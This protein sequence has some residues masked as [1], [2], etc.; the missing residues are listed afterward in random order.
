MS[1]GGYNWLANVGIEGV[2]NKTQSYIIF[3]GDDT[4]WNDQIYYDQS[5]ERFLDLMEHQGFA[6]QAVRTAFDQID[7]KNVDIKGLGF[8]RR[9]FPQSMVET[10][11]SFCRRNSVAILPSI[12]EQAQKIGEDVFTYHRELAEGA[13]DVLS[14][15][16]NSGKYRL[17]LFTAGDKEIQQW[18]LRDVN[19]GGNFEAVEIPSRKTI[20]SLRKLL[21][22]HCIDPKR[23]WMVGNSWAS[24]I[25]PALKLGLRAIWVQSKSWSYDFSVPSVN[26]VAI[27][28]LKEI[29]GVL[30]VY[31]DKRIR[32][33]KIP[34]QPLALNVTWGILPTSRTKRQPKSTQSASTE[35]HQLALPNLKE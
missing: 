34:Q 16:K 29:P 11:W 13:L 12:T 21:I 33:P 14:E 8:S 9:R 7:R 15:L 18:K 6:Q 26:C 4:L 24:D 35:A 19:I 2:M 1:S 27:Q 30:D 20:E 22:K 17:F 32:P 23:T 31:S 28:N 10:Y 25:D 3:D 5:I